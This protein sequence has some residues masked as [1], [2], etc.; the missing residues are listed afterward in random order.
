MAWKWNLVASLPS[1]HPFKNSPPGLTIPTPVP[2]TRLLRQT[3]FS[4]I[5]ISG[6]QLWFDASD[7]DGNGS[8]P[9][10]GSALGSWTDKSSNAYSLT[11]PTSSNQ[12]TYTTGALNRLG[13]VQFSG[14]TFLFRAG[15]NMT[16]FGTGSSTSVFMVAR[17][18][19][20]NTSW[21]IFHTYFF[22]SAGGTAPSPRYHFS[23]NQG[24]TQ[25]LTLILN[26]SALTV[27][28]TSWVTPALSNAIVGFTVSPSFLTMNWNGNSQRYASLTLNNAT[29]A[30][31]FVFQ[32]PRNGIGS[33]CIIYEM[34]G[35]NTQLTTS[36]SQSIEGY[37][38]WKWGLVGSLP[39]NH[40]FK[41]FPPPP[42]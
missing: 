42:N 11:Q 8:T 24:G 14:S 35:Y 30:T 29:D 20:T 4:P 2:S 25:G 9:T 31:A 38:A 22:T 39:A 37:L 16:N 26:N 10:N 23:F 27:Q 3:N 41:N 12:P 13:G 17:N 1:N 6:N 5:N 18:A 32:D 7:L 40:P 33:N 15:S 34:V 21:N 28:N 19:S 36:Q